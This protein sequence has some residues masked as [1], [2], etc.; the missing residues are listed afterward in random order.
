MFIDSHAH[1]TFPELKIDLPEVINRAKAANLSAIINIALDDNALATS[2]KMA[3]EFPGYIFNAYG[4]HPHDA[5]GWEDEI[6]QRVRA[7]AKEKKII[8]V[9]ETGLD[10]H[11]RLS[12]IERQ[13]EIFRKFLQLAQELNLPAVIHSREATKDTLAI[14][15]EENQGKLQGVLHCFN[16]DMELA[17]Q[18]LDTGLHISFTGNITFPKAH[19]IRQAAKEIPLERIMI[20]TDCPFLA[21]QSFRGKRNEPA[22]VAEVAK[23]IAEIKGLTVEEVAEET[24][25]NTRQ[26]FKI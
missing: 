20:E 16:G 17:K 8:A 6:A 1:L 7:L 21:P 13:K 18:A 2:L 26:L 22:Y 11:Y 10:Y 12:P 5:S 19:S 23:Q 4:L 3:E 15:H 14:I 25:K 9:G 24:T